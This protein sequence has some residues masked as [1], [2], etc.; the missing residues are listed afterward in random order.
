MNLHPF[1][2]LISGLL[3]ILWAYSSFSKVLELDKFK[4]AMATQVFPKWIGKIFVFIIP[5]SEIVM[6]TLL[7]LPDTRLIGMYAS[8]IM[9]LAFT[10]Y[11]A[12]SVFE[13][14]ERKPCACGGLF[15][16]LGWNR[17]LNVN[18]ILTL[19]ALTGIIL[20]KL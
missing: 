20:M 1:I 17:H 10:I 4:H 9:M 16:R 6:I 8:F 5:L 12:G 18:A 19:I 14:Y 2:I 15:G 3:I 13:I 11:V 7:I